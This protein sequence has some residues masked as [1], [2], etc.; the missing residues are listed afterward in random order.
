MSGSPADSTLEELVRRFS[1]LVRSVASRVGGARGRQIADDVEQEVFVNIWKQLE[2]EQPIENPSSYIYRCAVRE[3]LRLLNR[4]RRTDAADEDAALAVSDHAPRP[5]QRVLAGER[6]EAVAEAIKALPIDR[7]R[8][9]QA[10]LA[11]FSVPEVMQMYGWSYER[12]RNL[13]TRGMADLRALL[14]TRGID[15]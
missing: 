12:A 1:R 5:D 14:K 4:E 7:R 13:S 11:G 8:A 15:G 10:Y 2:R 9:V 6:G 3:T